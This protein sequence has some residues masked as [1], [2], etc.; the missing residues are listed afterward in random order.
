MIEHVKHFDLV[1]DGFDQIDLFFGKHNRGHYTYCQQIYILLTKSDG[2]QSI[3]MTAFQDRP[4]AHGGRRKKT[5]AV[6]CGKLLDRASA[7]P[8]DDTQDD[9]RRS[10][11]G[12]GFGRKIVDALLEF[13]FSPGVAV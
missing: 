2:S 12:H 4:V 13:F 5:I 1:G 7:G 10:G 9:P 8:I 11:E 6:L 3:Y